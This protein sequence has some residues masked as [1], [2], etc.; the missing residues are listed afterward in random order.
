MKSHADLRG[1]RQYLPFEGVLAGD[2]HMGNFGV[3]PLSEVGGRR[4]MV[5]VNLDF[6]DAGRGPFVLDFIR[7]VIASKAVNQQIKRRSL[8]RGYIEGLIGRTMKSPRKVQDSLDIRVSDYDDMVA[9]YA[10]KHSSKHG[11][12]LA[13]GEIQ[14]YDAKVQRSTIAGLFAEES[15]VDLAIRPEDRGGSAGQL[16]I[17]VL[18]TGKQSRRRIV[19]LKQFA[20][21]AIAQYCDQPAVQ[22][23]LK[24]IREAFWP[25]L[26]SSAYDLVELS[27]HGF[28]WIREKRVPLIDVPY[29][30]AKPGEVEFVNELAIYDANQ[31]GL[32]HGRQAQAATFRAAIE[33]DTDA[34]HQATEPVEDA[35]LAA[36]RQALGVM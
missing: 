8:E 1:L 26:D 14:T 17:W 28:F 29:S 19:E 22:P 30:S 20:K 15:V 25:G 33:K 18:L 12:R 7:Y 2:P 34:F 32:A 11:F 5:F 4:K 16:R 10:D 21:P 9:E 3:I 35:Y 31:L 24:A 23:W 6:D 27:P 13:P 36:A